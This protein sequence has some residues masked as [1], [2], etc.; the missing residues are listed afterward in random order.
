ML[1]IICNILY[2]APDAP[3]VMGFSKKLSVS[4]QQKSPPG[5]FPSYNHFVSWKPTRW[6][7]IKLPGALGIKYQGTM[8]DTRFL[9][10]SS[11]DP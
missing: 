1:I 8:S 7:V 9:L 4:T 11:P 2:L 6:A 10:L 5:Q 3:N